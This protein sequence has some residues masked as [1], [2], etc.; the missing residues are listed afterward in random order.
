[1]AEP[2]NAAGN[3]IELERRGQQGVAFNQPFGLAAAGFALKAESLLQ[4]GEI[5]GFTGFDIANG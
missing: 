5:P 3:I 4:Q 2:V 1:M